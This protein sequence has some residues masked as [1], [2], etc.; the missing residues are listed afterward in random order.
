MNEPIPVFTSGFC[1]ISV[2]NRMNASAFRNL[3]ARVMFSAICE[4]SKH[5]ELLYIQQNYFFAGCSSSICS[6]SYSSIFEL[7]F[8]QSPM[9]A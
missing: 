4:L 9:F 1:S 2:G 7:L 3:L 6:W 8:F 5:H